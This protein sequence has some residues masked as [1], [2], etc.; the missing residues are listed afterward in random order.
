MDPLIVGTELE[1]ASGAADHDAIERF[2]VG[3]WTLVRVWNPRPPAGP[4]ERLEEADE[5]AQ[6]GLRHVVESGHPL[7]ATPSRMQGGQRSSLERL[8][9]REDR[10]GVLAAVGVGAVA[11][12]A[13]VLEGARPSGD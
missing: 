1:F 13:A 8:H 9:P 12:G 6:F 4:D 5:G 3:E 10:R 7:A 2:A 11:D